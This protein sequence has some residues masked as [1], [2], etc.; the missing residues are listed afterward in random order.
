MPPLTV[1]D[2]VA[3]PMAGVPAGSGRRNPD[4]N[5]SGDEL[6]SVFE[7]WPLERVHLLNRAVTCAVV[8][9]SLGSLLYT[10]HGAWAWTLD[11]LFRTY[12]VFA[13]TVMAHEGIHGLLGRT[14]PANRWWAR[15]ALLPSMV[16]YTNFRRTHLLH[17]RFTNLEDKDP[18]YYVKPRRDWELPLRAIG[19]PHHWFF[20][21]LKRGGI[22]RSHVVNLLLNYAGI[23]LVYA[24]F[25]AVVGPARL[26]WGMFPT[27]ILVSLLLW[28]PFAYKTH[29]GFST[30]SARTR[31]HDYYGH[32]MFWFSLGLSLHRVHHMRPHLAWI[33]LRQFVRKDP[34]RSFRL[35]PRRNI[36]SPT[37]TSVAC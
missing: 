2:S 5:R 17:H 30:G 22:D 29:E 9:G 10:P 19:M 37:N 31:S 26:F 20:W 18:D 35:F 14:R 13:G 33:E 25:L 3:H 28:Y 15:I 11:V 12:L 16:P 32:F 8:A 6:S 4:R 34:V 21:L 36:E 23:A 27:L 7:R 24:V 1:Q